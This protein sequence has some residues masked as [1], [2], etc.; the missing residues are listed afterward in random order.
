MIDNITVQKVRHWFATHHGM[1]CTPDEVRTSLERN[2]DLFRVTPEALEL[3]VSDPTVPQIV[4]DFS[5]FLLAVKE[6]RA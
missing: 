3:T 4:K 1:E 2:P 5:T 6:G